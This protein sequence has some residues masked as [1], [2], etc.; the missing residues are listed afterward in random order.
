MKSSITSI[1]LTVTIGTILSLCS[2]Q[3]T[4]FTASGK[5]R[6]SIPKIY[7]ASAGPVNTSTETMLPSFRKSRVCPKNYPDGFSLRCQTVTGSDFPTVVFRVASQV[8]HKEHRPPYYINENTRQ[9]L[10]RPFPYQNYSRIIQNRGSL[11]ITC[12]VRTRKPVW[13]DVIPEC[14]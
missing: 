5:Q 10:I 13:V 14:E 4:D 3:G 6:P 7:V 8:F 2:G 1:V 11:R 9:G 12:R